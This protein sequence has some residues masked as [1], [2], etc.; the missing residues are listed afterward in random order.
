MSAGL[1]PFVLGWFFGKS[2]GGFHLFGSSTSAQPISHRGGGVPAHRAHPAPIMQPEH[3]IPMSSTST[4]VH[5]TSNVPEGLPP[6]PSGWRPTATTPAV[7]SRA[8]Q[9][10]GTL[11]VGETKYEHAG[12]GWLAFHASRE[13][14]KK[15]VTAWEPKG[16]VLAP[17]VSV[18]HVSPYVAPM[19]VPVVSPVVMQ[20]P[21]QVP[22]SHPMLARGSQGDAVREWQRRIGV[23]DDGDFGPT[24]ERVTRAWQLHHG[25]KDDGVVGP[26]TWAAS[27]TSAA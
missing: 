12:S 20:H 25:L 4:A 13:A 15:Y 5:W 27:E 18:P 3:A 9:L 1:V 21:A 23:K 11:P 6:F 19:G 22:V 26:V 10:L 24:T 16:V 17:S 8:S 14:G 2:S 7:I